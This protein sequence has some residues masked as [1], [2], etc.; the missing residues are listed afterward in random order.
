MPFIGHPGF[1]A[2]RRFADGDA[3]ER[4]RARVARHME[5][6]TACREEVT[7]LRQLSADARALEAPAMHANGF[8]RVRARRAAGDRVIIPVEKPPRVKRSFVPA[9]AAAALVMGVLILYTLLAPT[10]GLVAGPTAGEL[11]IAPERPTAG[12]TV[13]VEYIP[14]STLAGE[15]LLHL[16][17]EYR[18]GLGPNDIERTVAA[19]LRRQRNGVYAGSFTIPD[20]VSYA[21]MVVETPGGGRVDANGGAPWEIIVHGSDGRPT[22]EALRMR[23]TS[24]R[25]IDWELGTE[26]VREMSRHYPHEP[27]G[28]RIL[29]TSD[30]N[31]L[32]VDARDSLRMIY[33][34]IFDSLHANLSAQRDVPVDR[35]ATMIFF[36]TEIGARDEAA[37]PELRYWKERGYREYPVDY[38]MVQHRS[39]DLAREHRTPRPFLAAAEQLWNEG[40]AGAPQLAFDAWNTVVRTEDPEL[41]RAWGER[42][43]EALPDWRVSVGT[44]W[45]RVP[46]LRDRGLDLMRA[47]L[48]EVVQASPERRQLAH[49]TSAFRRVNERT[50]QWQLEAIGRAQLSAGNTAAA[51]D[52]LERAAALGWRTTTDR[53]LADARLAAGDTAGALRA[54]MRVAADPATSPAFTD[55]VRTRFASHVTADA[56]SSG[57]ATADSTMRHHILATAQRRRITP[58]MRVAD[59]SG[60]LQPMDFRR[61]GT[62]SLV[63]F[64]SRYCPPSNF[65]MPALAAALPRLEAQGVRVMTI[66]SEPPS[67]VAT[68]AYAKLGWSETLM[69]DTRAEASRAFRQAGT[70][71]FFVVDRDGVT[72]IDVRSVAEALGVI[73]ALEGVAVRGVVAQPGG[74]VPAGARLAAPAGGN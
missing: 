45:S 26:T 46:E 8:D 61:G 57:L 9:A 39:W 24:V 66:V 29:Y 56:W 40:G 32:G 62:I 49:D 41:L 38:Y 34:P 1:D 3:P 58:E 37:N 60:Q 50:Q 22:F 68:E 28:W 55:S 43:M 6:C 53:A 16:R 74:G 27:F 30:L 13:R 2:L 51:L 11:R 42:L 65:Q 14:S 71:H 25:N 54:W 72:A 21:A 47:S 63:A 69:Y 48:A 31:L 5:S 10:D 7:A 19:E 18:H 17:L 64:V 23:F 36:A 70:P 44:A 4:E 12:S 52:T 73:A 33:R 59:A 35:I 67:G 20:T 15:P